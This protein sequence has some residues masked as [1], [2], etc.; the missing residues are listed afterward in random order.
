MRTS[1][2]AHPR[3]GSASQ[4]AASRG[5][6]GRHSA[7]PAATGGTHQQQADEGT[8]TVP[9]RPLVLAPEHLWLQQLQ[10]PQHVQ[11]ES[12]V[13]LLPELVE[14]EVGAAVQERS[15]HG[16][17]PGDA[18]ELSAVL[19]PQTRGHAAHTRSWLKRLSGLTGQ[20]C[21][22]RA[23]SRDQNR[24]PPTPPALGCEERPCTDCPLLQSLWSLPPRL[25][26]VRSG[27]CPT[28][29]CQA[30]WP[31]CTSAGSPDP[32]ARP[33]WPRRQRPN[34]PR[35]PAQLGVRGRSA[36]SCVP[37]GPRRGRQYLS[38]RR[39]WATASFRQAMLASATRFSDA[40][41][42]L[43][44]ARR[45]MKRCVR[46]SSCEEGMQRKERGV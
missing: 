34:A 23:F 7:G 18:A 13:V 21:W 43:V 42:S 2:C 11:E 9:Q 24:K 26:C 12:E 41:E 30:S 6:R 15:D 38:S 32:A 33:H 37:W 25:S 8:Q 10:H 22:P 36:S 17:V 16:Q 5:Q 19:S 35:A 29:L 45:V 31:L 39:G 28:G 27:N 44:S 20:G 46:T 4:A 3:R 1:P 14:V 40:R